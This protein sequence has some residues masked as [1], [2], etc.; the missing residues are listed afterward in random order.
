ML[1][2]AILASFP[3]IPSAILFLLTPETQGLLTVCSSLLHHYLQS[4]YKH[5]TTQYIFI[6]ALTRQGFCSTTHTMAPS[7]QLKRANGLEKY[8]NHAALLL[9]RR[10]WSLRCQ[11]AFREWLTE[12][13]PGTVHPHLH[14]ALAN[15][16]SRIATRLVTLG[17]QRSILPSQNKMSKSWS[18]YAVSFHQELLFHST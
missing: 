2:A 18:F 9:N 17:H 8:K 1:K 7:A 16:E 5:L 10:S 4:S 12:P 15:W 13:E 14:W 11:Q 3:I 6:N